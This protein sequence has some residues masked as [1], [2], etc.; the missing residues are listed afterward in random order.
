MDFNNIF[1][2][3]SYIIEKE[4]LNISSFA[5]KIGV[6]DQ[7]IRNII[8]Y[9]RSNPGYEVLLKIIQTFNWVDANWL[10]SGESKKMSDL[11][12]DGCSEELIKTNLN[13]SE[14]IKN[15]SE[16]IKSLTNKSKSD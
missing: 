9:Q 11:A 7:T 6:G 13:L 1:D 10:I 4:G 8:T 14:T 15:L 16:T 12:N 3:I 2:R 5:K